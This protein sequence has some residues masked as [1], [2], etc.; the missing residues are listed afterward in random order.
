MLTHG[1]ILS[2]NF[3]YQLRPLHND[4]DPQNILTYSELANKKNNNEKLKETFHQ[5]MLI[6][7]SYSLE[8]AVK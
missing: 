7:R 4:S 2:E 6:F 3:K 8:I 1:Q 5:Q